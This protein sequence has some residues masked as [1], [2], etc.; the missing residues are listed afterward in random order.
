[1][2]HLSVLPIF[3]LLLTFMTGCDNQGP[4]ERAGEKVDE[5]F[6]NARES[7]KDLGNAIEDACEDIKEEAG[8]EDKDC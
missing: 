3:I 7:G 8:A 6:E 1:M 4:A 2:K 5:V